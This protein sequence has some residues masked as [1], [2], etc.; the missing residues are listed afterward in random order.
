MA[1]IK[2][3]P[4]REQW[5]CAIMERY[6]KN[7]QVGLWSIPMPLSLIPDNDTVLQAVSTFKVKHTE[8]PN[9]YELYFRLCANGSSM[10]QGTDFDQ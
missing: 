2:T 1:D 10:K 5:Y 6:I 7:H 9:I 4:F 3:D 8:V